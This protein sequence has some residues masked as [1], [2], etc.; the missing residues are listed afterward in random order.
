V[1]VGFWHLHTGGQGTHS[2]RIIKELM[3]A[4]QAGKPNPFPERILKN[5]EDFPTFPRGNYQGHAGWND[6]PWK[7]HRIQKG[8][9][10]TVELY[11]LA[12]DPMEANDLAAKETD[13][14]DKMLEELE[15]WQAS[16]FDSWEGKDYAP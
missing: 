3:E 9:Q 16:V 13:R 12:D 2:D 10:V 4:Q 15:Q 6:W 5:V 1:E 8:D 11:H 7:L 14:A